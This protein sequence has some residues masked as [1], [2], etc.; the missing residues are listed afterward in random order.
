[1]KNGLRLSENVEEVSLNKLWWIIFWVSTQ[2]FLL[3]FDIIS[4][5]TL[6]YIVAPNPC[7]GKNCGQWCII[8]GDMAGQCDGD[9]KCSFDYGNLGCGRITC[10]N[11]KLKCQTVNDLVAMFTLLFNIHFLL[12]IIFFSINTYGSGFK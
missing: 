1:V 11:Y 2:V 12:Q 3:L 6:P 9:G 8:G 7:E 5:Y 10:W 4:D